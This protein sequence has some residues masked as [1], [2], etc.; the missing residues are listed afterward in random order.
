MK[1]PERGEKGFREAK[2]GKEDRSSGL[3]PSLLA[4]ECSDAWASSAVL[5]SSSLGDFLELRCSGSPLDLLIQ[6]C[7]SG[8]QQARI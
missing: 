8:A 2:Q 4:W 1:A 3:R 5:V 7:W 6:K